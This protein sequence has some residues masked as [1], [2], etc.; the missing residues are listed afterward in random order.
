MNLDQLHAFEGVIRKA[1]PTF[2]VAY[3]DES[4]FMK[5]LGFFVGAFNPSFMINFITTIGTTVYF[6]TKAGYESNPDGSFTVLAHEWV[7]MTDNQKKGLWF[8]FSYL[9]PQVL[10]PLPL[11][12]F[13]VGARLH[14]WPLAFLVLGFV[15]ACALAKTSKVLFW[16]VLGLSAV[17]TAGLSIWLAKWWSI[18]LFAGPL[19]ALP[20]PSPGRTHWEERGYAMTVAC[21]VWMTGGTPSAD[22]FQRIGQHFWGPDYYFMS[23][24]H[25]GVTDALNTAVQRA[26]S[27]DLR[28]EAPYGAV[29]DFL[30]ANGGLAQS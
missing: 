17:L 12:A 22:M 8:P 28:S 13:I 24:G 14:A 1:V 27:G 25:Q 11:L 9:F 18:A 7:H 20:W 23:W 16:V 5:L 26:M 10:M 2:K 3:K 21:F 4:A 6:P 19:C 29:Y 30:A 15:A